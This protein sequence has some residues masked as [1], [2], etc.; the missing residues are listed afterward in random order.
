[1]FNASLAELL[2]KLCIHAEHTFLDGLPKATPAI[3]EEAWSAS[4]IIGTTVESR[5]FSLFL[6]TVSSRP[7]LMGLESSG[8]SLLGTGVM[9][10]GD[11]LKAL[12]TNEGVDVVFVGVAS[13]GTGLGELVDFFWKNPR[14]DF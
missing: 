13:G 11:L 6:P 10:A 9:G 3:S 4:T 5:P 14:M 8:A 7:C 12:L 2:A 1:M